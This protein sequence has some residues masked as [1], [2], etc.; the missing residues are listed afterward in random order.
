MIS[1]IKAICKN[2]K[3]SPYYPIAGKR[4]GDSYPR[5]F[6]KWNHSLSVNRTLAAGHERGSGPIILQRSRGSSQTGTAYTVLDLLHP[7]RNP[8]LFPGIE[9]A[10]VRFDI[11]NGTPVDRIKSRHLKDIFTPP[12]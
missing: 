10:D 7:G 12:D 9:F 4:M 3:L 2:T 8:D 6:S 11:D 5:T 1:S